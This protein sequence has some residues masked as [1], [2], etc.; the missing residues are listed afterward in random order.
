MATMPA[1]LTLTA[2]YTPVVRDRNNGGL[3]GFDFQEPVTAV[4]LS[5]RRELLDEII[6]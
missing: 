5:V 6:I 4:R 1:S 3:H 2:V